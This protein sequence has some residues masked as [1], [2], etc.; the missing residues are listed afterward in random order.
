MVKEGIVMTNS[1]RMPKKNLIVLW[2][3]KENLQR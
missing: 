3:S 2:S 1:E